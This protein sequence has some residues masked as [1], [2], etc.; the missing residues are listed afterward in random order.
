MKANLK[1]YLFYAG[2]FLIG[3]SISA[4]LYFAYGA[5]LFPCKLTDVSEKFSFSELVG[6]ASAVLKPLTYLF[7]SAYTLYACAVSGITTLYVGA[8]FGRLTIR[9]CMSEHVAFTHGAVLIITLFIGTVFVILA[10][11]ATVLRGAMRTVSPDPQKLVKNPACI[12]MFKTYL[13]TALTAIA[14]SVGTYLLLL[15][16]KI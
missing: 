11:E 8:I 7:L 10:K 15:Y 4:G 12:S 1:Y 6:L 5:E 16:F 9:Y 3:A 2:I 14:V 13:S